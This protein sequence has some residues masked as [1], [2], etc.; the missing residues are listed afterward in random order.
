MARAIPLKLLI[1]NIVLKRE[2]G[3]DRDRNPVFNNYE[4]KK[5]KGCA[6]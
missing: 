4:I 6:D 2:S 5:C 3:K 1:H